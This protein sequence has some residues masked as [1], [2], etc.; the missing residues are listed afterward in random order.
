MLTM[1]PDRNSLLA[2]FSSFS[3][4]QTKDGVRTVAALL[5]VGCLDPSSPVYLLFFLNLT[6]FLRALRHD[7]FLA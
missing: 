3:P 7:A 1:K 6:C 2:S 5:P 4:R